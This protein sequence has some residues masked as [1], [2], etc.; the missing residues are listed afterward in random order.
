MAVDA[1]LKEIVRLW[2][3]FH[4]AAAPEHTIAFRPAAPIAL[5]ASST[6]VLASCA[7]ALTGRIARSS[8]VTAGV[9]HISRLIQESDHLG[10]A[11]GTVGE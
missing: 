5:E 2:P 6:T 4:V 10:V 3:K 11:T 7:T 1:S 8:A 9:F